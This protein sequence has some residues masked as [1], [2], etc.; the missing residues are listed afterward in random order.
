[1][2][3]RHYCRFHRLKWGNIIKQQQQAEKYYVKPIIHNIFETRKLRCGRSTISWQVVAVAFQPMA[4]RMPRDIRRLKSAVAIPLYRMLSISSSFSR[5]RRSMS[6]L[7]WSSWLLED[8]RRPRASLRASLAS[9]S[10][11]DNP[12]RQI[13]LLKYVIAAF[14]K[15]YLV[16]K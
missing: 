9:A 13:Q 12:F 5:R 1:M 8:S 2:F 4:D 11:L 15:N 14:I 3:G 7:S 16:L 6:A 10:S